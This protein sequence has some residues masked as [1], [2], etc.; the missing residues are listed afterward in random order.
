MIGGGGCSLVGTVRPHC[1][2]LQPLCPPRPYQREPGS[3]GGWGGGGAELHLRGGGWWCGGSLTSAPSK[4]VLSFGFAPK[5]TCTESAGENVLSA[6]KRRKK[7]IPR[8]LKGGGGGSKGGGIVHPG[9]RVVVKLSGG[10][11]DASRSVLT[12]ETVSA[13]CHRLTTGRQPS[14]TQAA[15]ATPRTRCG[16]RRCTPKRCRPTP[17]RR[18]SGRAAQAPGPSTRATDGRGPQR[19]SRRC[20]AVRQ[21]YARVLLLCGTGRALPSP[22]VGQHVRGNCCSTVH[23]PLPRPKW[24]AV[25]WQC[26]HDYTKKEIKLR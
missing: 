22:P 18:A 24:K 19:A 9:S 16:A 5:R 2:A 8:S 21:R 7:T 25:V 26:R 17:Q 11:V 15:P 10:A 4:L 1:S 6:K 20:A 3:G 12:T 13:P 14:A 23:A